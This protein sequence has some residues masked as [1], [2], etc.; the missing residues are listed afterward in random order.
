MERYIAIDNV[1]AWPNLT[2]LPDGSIA[3]VIFNQ[4]CH[5]AWEGDVECWRSTDGGI[6]WAKS[7]T[8]APHA[9]GTAR[10]N[11]AAG[12]AGDGALVVICS[13]E[14]PKGE[15]GSTPSAEYVVLPPM[16]CRSNDNG[17]TWER[18][19]TVVLPAIAPHWIPF[20][21]I[22]RAAD[23]TLAVSFYSWY[24]DRRCGAYVFFSRDDGRIWG[25]AACIREEDH[26]E[27]TLLICDDGCWLAASRTIADTHLDLF[28]SEDAGATW[29]LREALTLPGQHP[30]NLLQLAD[31]SVLLT[32][33][34]RNAGSYGVA[35]RISSDRGRTWDAPIVL[36]SLEEAA[37]GGYPSS[38][39]L[40]DGTI[41]TAYYRRGVPFHQRYFMGILR[42]QPESQR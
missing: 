13:G 21:D 17:Q 10:L 5:G 29:K 9:P 31:G 20:G 38:V 22:V 6:F 19:G 28:R 15:P 26:N 8:P 37:D 30:A 2:L 16:V 18:G 36:F 32:Y 39:Q 25:D 3:A 7:G 1:C 4:P 34:L 27:T 14:S 23:G 40:A 41:V 24:M 42:W 35:A 12:L 11:H 33:G